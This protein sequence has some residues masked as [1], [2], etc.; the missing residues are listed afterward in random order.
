MVL[1][2]HFVCGIRLEKQ[3]CPDVT[4]HDLRHNFGTMAGERM[5]LEDVKTL[6]GHK[7][8]KAT[9]R[10]RKTREH[11]ATEEMQNVG[12]YMQKIMMSN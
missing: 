8:I 11:I 6:M 7:S 9:E 2:I 5:K 12:N 10:Y 1:S 4:L 3:W